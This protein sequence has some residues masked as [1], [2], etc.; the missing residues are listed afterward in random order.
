MRSQANFVKYYCEKRRVTMSDKRVVP[1]MERPLS[2]E[3]IEYTVRWI[4]KDDRYEA[5][6]LLMQ[7][8]T[9]PDAIYDFMRQF[10]D[11]TLYQAPEL[12]GHYL[13][14]WILKRKAE[15]SKAQLYTAVTNGDYEKVRV[16]LK[17]GVDVNGANRDGQTPLHLAAASNSFPMVA[18]L[19]AHNA[20]KTL[21]DGTGK[22]ASDLTSNSNIL[23][24]LNDHAT[25]CSV[26]ANIVRWVYDEVRGRNS[27]PIE[28]E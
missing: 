2:V 24:I 4:L 19:L 15:E 9:N 16:L 14:P 11:D 22:R 28:K 8:T 25:E 1:S 13:F 3:A 7:R 17:E 21:A 12:Q 6:R 27:G 23:R 18:L 10:L 5:F 26:R 20:D